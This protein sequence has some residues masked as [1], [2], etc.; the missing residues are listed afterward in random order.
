MKKSKTQRFALLRGA[1]AIEMF[2]NA[3]A[4][5]PARAESKSV[6]AADDTV[7]PRRTAAAAGRGGPAAA[8]GRGGPEK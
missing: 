2:E 8:A 3:T 1:K 4:R 6:A 7:L 5:R